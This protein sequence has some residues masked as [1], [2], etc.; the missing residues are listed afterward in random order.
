MDK[1]KVIHHQKWK[2]VSLVALNKIR[3]YQPAV[4]K[5]RMFGRDATP[6]SIFLKLTTPIWKMIADQTNTYLRDQNSEG[7][8][9]SKGYKMVDED[10][11][12]VYY[13]MRRM[14]ALLNKP[15][16]EECFANSKCDAD[17]RG[18]TGWLGIKRYCFVLLCQGLIVWF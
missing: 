2:N 9:L 13:A 14:I 17:Q 12:V 5:F 11:L 1:Y 3:G 7:K 18:M 16:L 6:A 15:T 8:L 10:D 4:A